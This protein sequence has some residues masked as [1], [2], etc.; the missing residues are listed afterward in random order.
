MSFGAS[1]SNTSTNNDG[2]NYNLNQFSLNQDNSSNKQSFS[3]TAVNPFKTFQGFNDDSQIAYYYQN[4]LFQN[5]LPNSVPFYSYGDQLISGM[6]NLNLNTHWNWEDSYQNQTNS[7]SM[8]N[9][10]NQ[11]GMMPSIQQQNNQFMNHMSF[12]YP[13]MQNYSFQNGFPKNFQETSLQNSTGY[14]QQNWFK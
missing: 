14:M 13:N 5:P 4:M 2:S 10:M 1:T 8:Q 11:F 6:Q 3:N 9:N 7:N 12:C